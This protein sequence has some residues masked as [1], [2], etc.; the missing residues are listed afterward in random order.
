MIQ[1][2]YYK[3]GFTSTVTFVKTNPNLNVN[4][5]FDYDFAE[6]LEVIVSEDYEG[7]V[8]PSNYIWRCDLPVA[9]ALATATAV[10]WDT[11]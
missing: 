7:S 5:R 2:T 9:L 3:G 1:T 6:V 8:L 11:H 4:F 10:E